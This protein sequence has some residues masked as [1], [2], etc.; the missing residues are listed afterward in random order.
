MLGV[1]LCSALQYLHRQGVL[2]LDVKP[3]N[4]VC[5]RGLA[6]LLDLDI[7][8]P[9]GRG[10]K[11]GTPEYMAPEQVL[12]GM[13][14]CATDVWGLGVVLFEAATGHLPIVAGSGPNDPPGARRPGHSARG[15]GPAG[16]VTQILRRMLADD[17]RARPSLAEVSRCLEGLAPDVAG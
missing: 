16:R 1:H 8:R 14:T 5:E 7:A 4:I 17:P 13:L 12:G 15:R 2:H 10:R 6:K 3:S 11:Q 9:P